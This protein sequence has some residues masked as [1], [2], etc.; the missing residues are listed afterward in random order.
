[1]P[2][3]F[4]AFWRERPSL[5]VGKLSVRALQFRMQFDDGMFNH[6]LKMA[7]FQRYGFKS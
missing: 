6:V 5:S 4:C 3:L 7:E 2:G 1:M